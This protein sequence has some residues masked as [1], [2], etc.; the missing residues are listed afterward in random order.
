M[1]YTSRNV[2]YNNLIIGIYADSFNGK[3]GVT[4]AYMNFISQFGTPFLITP[5]MDFH[6]ITE[7]IDA[8]VIPGGAD[9]ESSRYGEAPHYSTSR[10]NSHYE[11]LDEF[12]LPIYMK[13]EKP[14]LGICR[15]F[16]SLNVYFGG[17]LYQH[18][19]HHQQGGDRDKTSHVMYYEPLNEYID[20]NSLHHQALKRLGDGI[21]PLGFSPIYNKCFSLNKKEFLVLKPY[22]IKVK[23]ED[24]TVNYLSICEAFT[25]ETYPLFAVQ[26]HPEEINCSLTINY[27]DELL[28]QKYGENV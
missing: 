25:H 28:N 23:G 26:Y 3:T 6:R 2:L 10:A 5:N 17:S 4:D 16:Q 20:V 8:L 21:V 18:I 14:I 24:K 19:I 22:I 15:G 12:F 9:V 1:N 7:I 27:F 13:A 11:F